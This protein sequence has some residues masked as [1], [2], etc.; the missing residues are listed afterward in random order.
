MKKKKSKPRKVR[1]R[2]HRRIKTLTGEI[3]KCLDAGLWYAA[4]VL[5]LTLPDI[6]AALESS[7]GRT[8][9]ERY[10]EWCKKWLMNKYPLMKAKDLYSLRCGVAH[11]G[12]ARH[13]DIK[14]R[15]F[16]TVDSKEG[17]SA[18]MKELKGVLILDMTMFAKD[19]IDAVEA[20]YAKE[21][22]NQNLKKNLGALVQY[23][24]NGLSGYLEQPSIG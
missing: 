14:Y 20:W 2:Q 23:Y 8:R 6:C 1:R 5:I 12:R 22:K 18:N 21:A 7:S 11:Q 15:I 17:L 9:P 24:P 13:S 10:Q 19:M 16:F 4:L 3:K